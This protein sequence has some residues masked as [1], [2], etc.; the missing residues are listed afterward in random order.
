MID[1]IFVSLESYRESCR[2]KKHVGT[3]ASAVPPSAARRGATLQRRPTG[4]HAP[5][6]RATA[7]TQPQ[8]L[9]NNFNNIQTISTTSRQFQQH[10]KTSMGA[11]GL[12]SF[13]RPGVFPSMSGRA[14]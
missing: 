1:F 11:P 8:Q 2:K 5:D 6:P 12:A 10:T 4:F 3:A 7:C 13:A 9:R 14:G